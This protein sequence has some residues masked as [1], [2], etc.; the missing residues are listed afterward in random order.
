MAEFFPGLTKIID[1]PDESG[2]QKMP[3]NAIDHDAGSEGILGQ[4]ASGRAPGSSVVMGD[5]D[6]RV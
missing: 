6:R 2:S 5:G 4:S 3:P 1:R